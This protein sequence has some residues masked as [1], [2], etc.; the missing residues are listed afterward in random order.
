[1]KPTPNY[2]AVE[3]ISPLRGLAT[4]PPSM[5]LDPAY[6]P[7]LLNVQVRDGIVQRRS[8][9]RQLGRQLVG[10]VLAITEFGEIFGE[11]WF[12]VLTTHRQYAY[13]PIT[14]DFIDLT[15][16]QTSYPVTG[17]LSTSFTIAGDHVTDFTAGRLI[18]RIGAG[19]EGVFTVVSAVLDTGNTVIT[20][21]ETL[22]NLS[23]GGNIVIA[24]DFDTPT[25]HTIEFAA[26]TDLIG[27]RLIITNGA[28]TPR[29]W[30]GNL[31]TPFE[32]WDPSI[33]SF[34]TMR[35]LCV[36]NDALFLGGVKTLTIEQPTLV[37]WSNVGNF[38]DFTEGTSGLQILYP[39]LTAILAMKIL[40]DRLAIYST[41]AIMTAVFVDVPVVY[42]FEV[43]I[44]EGVRLVSPHSVL[45]VNV[46]HIYAS[47]ENF[48]L[49]DGTRGL[50]PLGDAI[51]SDY[52]ITKDQ[53]LLYSSSSLNDFSKRTFFFAF[54]AIEGGFMVYTGEYDVF[55]LS[56][57]RWAKEQYADNPTAFGFFTNRDVELTWEDAPW[58]V[59]SMPW[60]DELGA[61]AEESEQINFPI[62]AFG[63]D[64][65]YVFLVTE[66]VL[67]DNGVTEQES[68]ETCDFSIPSTFLSTL[69]RWAEVE[70]EA[71]GS[72]VNIAC[73]VNLGGSFSED[74]EITLTDDP[75]TY[76]IP[77]DFSGRT[78]RFRFTSDENFSLRWVRTWVREGSPR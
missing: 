22:T 78:I 2:Q 65:G 42:A 52:K 8:G 11:P 4:T 46:G 55:D 61:W 71:W 44:P 9:Y 15:P 51:Y 77:I 27:H 72:S 59:P 14:E 24:R 56:S 18:P 25:D 74:Q 43:V 6:S 19:A 39:L 76:R 32:D 68:Y 12:V 40:G 26:V 37:M 35:T 28:D 62:R 21:E 23:I 75:Q 17:V 16:D 58:E 67:S 31:N 5:R 54:P 57:I 38:D 13:D 10:R 29:V 50:R 34:I 36:F 48:Y 70:F 64:E 66:G 33:A 1:M 7:R 63:S 60:S 45:S 41:D 3:S 69:A 53:A 49:F 73:S 20:I 47:E 30:N